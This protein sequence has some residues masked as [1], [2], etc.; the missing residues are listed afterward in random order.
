[1][2]FSTGSRLVAELR[3]SIVK[4]LNLRGIIGFEGWI[5]K[6]G[7]GLLNFGSGLLNLGVDY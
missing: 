4:H 3:K 1:M 2:N 7:V 5:I 6:F